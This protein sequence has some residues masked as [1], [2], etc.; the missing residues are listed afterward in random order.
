MRVIF[1]KLTTE[2]SVY[3]AFVHQL[4]LSEYYTNFKL[5]QEYQKELQTDLNKELDNFES[6]ILSNTKNLNYKNVESIVLS[7]ITFKQK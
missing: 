2:I 6:T 7:N 1:E 3:E 5:N 4:K